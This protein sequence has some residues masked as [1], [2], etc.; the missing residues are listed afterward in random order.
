MIV[1]G[2]IGA[3]LNWVNIFLGLLPTGSAPD[4][5]LPSGV[6]V[7][8]TWLNGVFPVTESLAALGAVLGVYGVVFGF[9]LVVWVLTKTHLLGGS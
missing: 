6:V 3:C 4:L 5:G 2:F 7:G 9:R 1:D 8:Y